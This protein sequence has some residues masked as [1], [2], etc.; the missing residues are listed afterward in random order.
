LL[1]LVEHWNGSTWEIVPSPNV[2]EGGKDSSRLRGIFGA[3]ANDTWA[4]G[5]STVI[6]SDASSTLVLHWN[7][8]GWKIVPS[9]STKYKNI[10]NDD[11]DGGIAIPHGDIW[12]VGS[13]DVADTLVMKGIR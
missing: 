4:V 3:S 11:L 7:G 9:P 1:T 13:N 12:M 2:G 6:A 5:E 8:T 10:L